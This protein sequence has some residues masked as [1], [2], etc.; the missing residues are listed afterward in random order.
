MVGGFVGLISS[1]CIFCAFF[2]LFFLLFSYFKSTQRPIVCAARC[3]QGS[4]SLTHQN[5]IIWMKCNQICPYGAIS[6]DSAQINEL[7]TV[8]AKNLVLV[9]CTMMDP[10]FD[11]AHKANCIIAVLRK[12]MTTYIQY[13]QC[14]SHCINSDL[15][16]WLHQRRK[17]KFTFSI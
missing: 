4:H 3:A 2:W 6:I 17:I 5:R 7:I 1:A 10:Y 11:D 14:I 15:A 13:S 9:N 12:Y 16:K 8:Y